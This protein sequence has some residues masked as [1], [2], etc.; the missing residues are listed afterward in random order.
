MPGIILTSLGAVVVAVALADVF[1]TVLFP[2]SG[3]GPLREPLAKAVRRLFRL[4]RHLA[5]LQ[6]R[7][8]VLAYAGPVQITVTLLV[9]FGLLWVG[10]AAV[11]RPALGSSVVAA[12]GPTHVAWST[13]LYYSGYALTT[14]GTGDVV[15]TTAA[16]RLLTVAEAATGFATITLVISYFNSVYTT[17][18]ARNAFALALHHRSGGTGLGGRV[19]A[20]LWHEGDAGAAFHLA[21]M[22][23]SLRSITQTHRAYPVLRSFHYQHDYAAL[24]IILL[25]CLE[26]S[27]LL[28]TSLDLETA[29]P[30]HRSP[31]SG[32]SAT[33]IHDA[34]TALTS[35]LLSAPRRRPPSADQE[36]AWAA[37]HRRTVR[38]LSADRV[39]VR[40]DE[41]ATTAYVA[42]RAEWD[43]QLAELAEALLYDW[44][45]RLA[46]SFAFGAL[47]SPNNAIHDD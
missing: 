19:V 41:A 21:E 40:T 11:Y 3:H 26:T 15:A 31:L 32:T 33:E 43:L 24:P 44:P 38:D 7:R 29:A 27:T 28:R 45:E 10:W 46:P 17:L 39:P 12:S 8:R 14:L 16:Y 30:H 5:N 1:Y 2:A 47:S 34:A 13:A 36:R 25:T 23:G 20:A 37:H 9:W 6:R 42:M 18:T 4:T 35:Q 22:A